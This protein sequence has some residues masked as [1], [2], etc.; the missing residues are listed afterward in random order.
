MLKVKQMHLSMLLIAL[1]AIMF[2]QETVAGPEC[3]RVDV[4]VGSITLMRAEPIL[5]PQALDISKST[6]RKIRQNLFWAFIYN[7]IGLPLAASGILTP[8]F[9]GAAMALSSI[10]VVLNALSL[11]RWQP[12][13]TTAAP[14]SA[15]ASDDK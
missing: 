14:P 8:M 5:V 6:R 7:V 4:M 13:H 9:A 10:S 11:T 3:A 2:T 15:G 1:T 12:S